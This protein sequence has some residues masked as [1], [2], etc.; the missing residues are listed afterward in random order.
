[1]ME[2]LTPE[3]LGELLRLPPNRVIILARRGEIPSFSVD[4]RMRFD[5]SEVESWLKSRRSDVSPPRLVNGG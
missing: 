1:M 4:G 5:A 3:E 2:I